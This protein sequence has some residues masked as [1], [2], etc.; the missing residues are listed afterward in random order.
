MS[1]K[2]SDSVTVNLTLPDTDE[3]IG[4]WVTCKMKTDFWGRIVPATD[5]NHMNNIVM[6]H[7]FLNK[8]LSGTKL[9]INTT[10]VVYKGEMWMYASNAARL[11]KS[12]VFNDNGSAKPVEEIIAPYNERK[13]E[14]AGTSRLDRQTEQMMKVAPIIGL[15]VLSEVT[16]DDVVMDVAQVPAG[17]YKVYDNKN[18]V[19]NYCVIVND[20]L[21]SQNRLRTLA[22]NKWILK[23][24]K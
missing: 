1:V 20:T 10:P 12:E 16:V 2:I 13:A 5:P 8:I 11:L 22:T 7:F 18:N 3:L 21:D 19:V 4:E 15:T 9:I 24:I 14:Y 17:R 6:K 23:P